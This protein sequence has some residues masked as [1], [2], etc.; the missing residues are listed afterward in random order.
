MDVQFVG[1]T[2]EETFLVHGK[3]SINAVRGDLHY[4]DLRSCWGTGILVSPKGRRD[5]PLGVKC[6]LH[7]LGSSDPLPW[8][9]MTTPAD[10]SIKLQNDLAVIGAN[11]RGEVRATVENLTE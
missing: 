9:M 2:A 7:E 10:P 3:D 11:F 6:K 5:V 4:A 8:M 1:K